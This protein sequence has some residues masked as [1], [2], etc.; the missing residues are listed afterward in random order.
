L[1][2]DPGERQRLAEIAR[3]Y[4][5]ENLDSSR[6]LGEFERALTSCCGPKKRS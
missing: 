3:E 5:V 1:S 4:A 6:V 2:R